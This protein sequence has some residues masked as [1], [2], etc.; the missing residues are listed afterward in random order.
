MRSC[1][2]WRVPERSIN[3]LGF[4][5]V[6]VL[7]VIAIIGVLVGILLPAVQAAR[8]AAR[9]M[10]C[11]NNFK[12]VAL[13]IHNYHSAYKQLPRHRGGTWSDGNIPI[14][15]NNRMSL[16]YL[17]GLTP[18]FEQQ[19]VWEQ[20]A[21][22]NQDR[23]DGSIQSPPFPA[24]GPAPYEDQYV[25][26]QIE[27][28]TLR[29]PSDPGVG[30]PSFGRTNYAACLGDSIDVMDS[31]A[32]LINNDVIVRPPPS[33]LSA[34]ANAACRGAFV[35]RKDTKFRD[36]TDGL[37]NTILCG[38]IATDLGD[39]DVRTI[40]AVRNGDAILDEPDLCLHDGL[41]SPARPRFWS[42]GSDGGVAPTLPSDAEVRGFRWSQAGTVW[43]EFNTI[44]P[45]NREVC[46]GQSPPPSGPLVFGNPTSPPGSG[47]RIEEPGVAS[48][49]SRHPGGAHVM[50]ADGSILFVTD[51]IEAGDP[52][53]GNVWLDGAGNLAPGNESPYGLWGALGTRAA[54]EVINEPLN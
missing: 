17:V 53:S 28:P 29:C 26:W 49:S 38:E 45:P 44:L 42:T 37:S 47:A 21:N 22:P 32:V 7:V 10:S 3:R 51:S 13:A 18:F 15:M 9:R 14:D 8:E 54:K 20:I 40:P 41:V 31:G 36:I 46:L 27:I 33:W 25:P 30:L 52:H 11:S 1:L 19:S 43:T 34:R 23:V 35:P 2:K 4:T 48:I 5:L 6:E 12:Q 16:S 24:M 39:R 50:M